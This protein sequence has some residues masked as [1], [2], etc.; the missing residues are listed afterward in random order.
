MQY[1]SLDDKSYAES[2]TFLM[3][4]MLSI[5]AVLDAH[6]AHEAQQ[7]EQSEEGTTALSDLIS[8]WGFS[9]LTLSSGDV[10]RCV[11]IMFKHV[12]AQPSMEA[13]LI[14]DAALLNFIGTVQ[15]GYH[16]LNP[17]HNFRHAVD[18]LQALFYFLLSS[19]A[20]P[21][22]ESSKGNTA[23]GLIPRSPT[24]TDLFTPGY[25]LALMIVGLGHDV[26]HPGVN[27]GFLVATHAPLALLF[28]D[29]SVLENLHGAALSRILLAYWPATQEPTMRKIILELVLSTDMALHFDYMSRFKEIDAL[30]TAAAQGKHASAG[31]DVIDRLRS[32]I[33]AGLVKCAD[34]C[35]VA[36][37]LQ[38]SKLWSSVLLREFFNQSRL[39]RFVGLP[40]TKSF[41]P[42]QTVQAD[43]QIFF[44][45]MFAAPLFK[46][47]KVALPSLEPLI[48]QMESNKAYWASTRSA[49]AVDVIGVSP[50]ET[51]HF[52]PAAPAT[53]S[54][55]PGCFSVFH[56]KRQASS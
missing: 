17:Y 45:D 28:N 5:G 36:R 11:F 1:N 44:M 56:R 4:N 10:V 15:S 13:W 38:V 25:I 23:A 29:R 8:S 18:V 51:I 49:K 12:L 7:P 21:P 39:E 41:D 9:C 2:K 16:P 37:P 33:F 53:G 54:T 34:I 30:R 19:S 3:A 14:P 6:I 46:S 52:A 40:L 48:E 26:G 27:N 20:L 47:L 24:V 43:S 31:S 35:N 50:K 22:L 55:G 32:T 42:E